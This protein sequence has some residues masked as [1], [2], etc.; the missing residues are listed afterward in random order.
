MYSLGSKWAKG[1]KMI[2]GETV[3]QDRLGWTSEIFEF[4]MDS[5]AKWNLEV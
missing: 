1:N 3:G 2:L 5:R 4:L